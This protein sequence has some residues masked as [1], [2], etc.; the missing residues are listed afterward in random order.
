MRANCRR[1]GSCCFESPDR[2]S[3]MAEYCWNSSSSGARLDGELE[4]LE[5]LRASLLPQ[6]VLLH[7]GEEEARED[8]DE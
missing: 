6:L 7:V 8:A 2:A 5:E 1:T 4:M 3:A